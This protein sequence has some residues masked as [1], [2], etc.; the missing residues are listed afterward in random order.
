MN[1]F[2]L[3]EKLP[4]TTHGARSRR[5]FLKLMAG[6]GAAMGFTRLLWPT[7]SEA[8]EPNPLRFFAF[9]THHG[10]VTEFWTP[11]GG[12][13]D[14]DIDFQDSTL[15]P[16]QPFRDKL[17]ILDG[18]DYKVLYEYGSSGH[19]GGPCTFLTGSAMTMAGG[20]P[21]PKSQSLDQFLGNTVGSATR[22][23]S[24][25]LMGF[26]PF[27]GQTVYDSISFSGTGVRVP[28]ER[29]PVALFNRVFS[30]LMVGAP[31]PAETRALGRKK[32]LLDYLTRDATRLQSRLAGPEKQKLDAHLQALRDIEKRLES[33]SGMACTKPGKPATQT[34]N[35][36]GTLARAPE[37]TKLLM[38]LAVQ[39]MA[40]DLTRFVT[41]PGLPTPSAPWLN[42]TENLHDDLAH[43]LSNSNETQRL[44]IRSKLNQFHRWNAEMTAYL[45]GKMNAVNEGMGTLLDHSLVWW[46]NE[47]GEPDSHQSHGVPHVLAGGV[48]GKWRMGRYLQLRPGQQ[49][50]QGWNDIGDK[51]PN[52]V[53]HNKLLVS[54]AQAFDQNIETF[55]HAD[56]SGAL[57]GL[58]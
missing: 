26:S 9:Y 13:T 42:L 33:S 57:P 54:I 34:Y 1:K 46:G 21:L 22:F 30:A 25:Q 14:F 47:L 50:L 27:G 15:Q 7:V 49:P 29:D 56:Y 36:L 48:N 37:N 28:W 45:L 17:L 5:E 3:P 24:L 31:S 19:E 23:R 8:A 32:S 38:D 4:K 39:A 40:C 55:G 51:A 18:L 52:A 35:Q 58:V 11:K 41:L 20:E 12:E 2:F 44:M 43:Q 10:K 6:A 53:P 16:L